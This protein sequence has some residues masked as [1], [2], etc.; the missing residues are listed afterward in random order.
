MACVSM[1]TLLC[2]NGGCTRSPSASLTLLTGSSRRISSVSLNMATS[3]PTRSGLLH[4]SFVPS[5]SLSLS[6][7]SSFSGLSLGLD[8]NP[9]IGV[10]REKGR[11]LV[12]RAGKAALCTT[13]RNRSRKSLARTHGF[14]KR[15]ST[16][17]GRAVLKRRRAKGRWVLC[18]KSNHNSGKRP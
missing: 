8:R 1:G 9:S 7:P 18:T 13:K 6:L 10:G 16:T 5:S 15:M 4:C 2:S 17:S 3:A 11:G 14:R 12:V